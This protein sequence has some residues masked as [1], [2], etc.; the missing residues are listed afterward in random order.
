ML[1]ALPGRQRPARRTS[2]RTTP[3]S[4]PA[5]PPRRRPDAAALVS[6]RLATL[7]AGRPPGYPSG[8]NR[9]LGVSGRAGNLPAD[10]SA[11]SGPPGSRPLMPALHTAGARRYSSTFMSL[12]SSDRICRPDRRPWAGPRNSR[13]FRPN[14]SADSVLCCSSHPGAEP[15]PGKPSARVRT[16]RPAG[17]FTAHAEKSEIECIPSGDAHSSFEFDAMLCL[18]PD[19]NYHAD[20]ITG[21]QCVEGTLRFSL[22][23]VRE[24]YICD[25]ATLAL[26]QLKAITVVL[27]EG[28]SVKILA[29]TFLDI[30]CASVTVTVPCFPTCVEG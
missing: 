19:G 26:G 15:R 22:G 30:Y 28:L 5:I 4:D 29:A 18:F 24:P 2:P 7:R 10:L 20:F 17:R 1:P 3:P 16:R 21:V 8:R 13:W 12:R 9:Q 6:G 23:E 11:R 27:G 25:W 14:V